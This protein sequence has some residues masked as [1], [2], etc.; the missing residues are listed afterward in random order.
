MPGSDC[1]IFCSSIDEAQ[2]ILNMIG[3]IVV[4]AV[5]NPYFLVPIS[6]MA[7]AFWFVR[8]AY[9]KTSRS[10][11]RLEANGEFWIIIITMND[12]KMYQSCPRPP[13]L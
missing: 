9:L 8:R 5:V 1:G 13:F 10:I 7:I 12:D 3:A 2:V 11:K 4:T 6:L